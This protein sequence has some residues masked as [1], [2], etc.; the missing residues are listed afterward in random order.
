MLMDFLAELG[1]SQGVMVFKAILNYSRKGIPIN[2]EALGPPWMT[3]QPLDERATYV[4]DRDTIYDQHCS[5]RDIQDSDG[6]H[7]CTLS[8]TNGGAV[9]P[10]NAFTSR[11]PNQVFFNQK[12][13]VSRVLSVIEASIV[14]HRKLG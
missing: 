7:V 5:L 11:L 1:Q 3:T 6:Q 2:L 14:H 9:L 8:T 12:S 4:F 10:R 13:S